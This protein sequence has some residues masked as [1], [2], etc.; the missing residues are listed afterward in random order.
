MIEMPD[1]RTRNERDKMMHI[2]ASPIEKR[3]IERERETMMK[4]IIKSRNV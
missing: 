1:M 3:E 4:I 2:I